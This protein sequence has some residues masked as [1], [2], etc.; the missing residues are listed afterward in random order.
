MVRPFGCT[1]RAQRA[2]TGLRSVHIYGPTLVVDH[3]RDHL[4]GWLAPLDAGAKPAPRR[5]GAWLR[6]QDQPDH[7]PAERR[8]LTRAYRRQYLP[9]WANAWSGRLADLVTGRNT[10]LGDAPAIGQT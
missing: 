6:D 7:M 5:Y 10:E 4:D 2:A 1:V 9:A 3:L 8:N